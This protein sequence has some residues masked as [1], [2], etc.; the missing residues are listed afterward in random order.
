MYQRYVAWAL[1]RNLFVQTVQGFTIMGVVSALIMVASAQP[2]A[3]L[4]AFLAVEVLGLF[5]Y[6]GRRHKDQ[7]RAASASAVDG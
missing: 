1:R 4:P 3:A 7:R 2:Q 5:V 6:L